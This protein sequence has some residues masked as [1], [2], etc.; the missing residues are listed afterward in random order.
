MA[1]ITRY[2]GNL[3]AFASSATGTERTIFGDV[4][5]SDTLD[6]NITADFFRGWGILLSSEIPTKQDFNGLAFTMSQVLAYMHQV[7]VPEWQIAHE[8][9]TDSI[10]NRNGVL[11]FSTVDNNIGTDPATDVSGDWVLMS[12]AN[13]SYDNTSSGLVAELVQDAL[14]ELAS[15][16][17]IAITITP[18]ADAAV[19]LTAPQASRD[20]LVLVDG[21]WTAGNDVI[22]PNESRRWYVDNTAGS[23]DALAKTAAGA[24]VVVLAGDSAILVCDGVDMLDPIPAVVPA[25]LDVLHI[26][27]QKP[28]TTNGGS[29]IVGTQVRALNTVITNT[30]SGASLGSNRITLPPGTYDVIARAPGREVNEHRISLYNFTDSSIELLGSS[31]R[32]ANGDNTTTGSFI[33]GRF[34]IAA[35]KALELHHYTILAVA[36]RGL[37]SAVSDGNVEIYSDI[38]IRK[39]S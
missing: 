31:E 13:L 2:D 8:Y 21:L 32:A 33:Y 35:S 5:Q 37:G 12:A 4:A 9:H 15:S 20:R 7:G 28:T 24:G 39:V 29:S 18:A 10:T 14:D 19:T 36:T 38:Q 1:K 17:I 26:Q 6:D 34:T 30:I 25:P 27:D 22:F 23:F 16:S 3:L 11:Y